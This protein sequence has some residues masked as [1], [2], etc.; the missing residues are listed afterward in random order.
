MISDFLRW[1]WDW[2]KRIFGRSKIIFANVMGGIVEVWVLLYDPL[3]MFN[4]DEVVGVDKH[5]LAVGIGIVLSIINV[6]LRNW[7][8]DGPASFRALPATP[9]PEVI[10]DENAIEQ[11]PKA[12]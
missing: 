4:W 7:F 11:S 10:P 2:T 9:E 8:S 3:T 5:Y 1:V 6:I 12:L